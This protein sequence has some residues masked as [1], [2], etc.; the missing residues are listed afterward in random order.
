MVYQPTTPWT[1]QCPSPDWSAAADSCVSTTD[2]NELN[3]GFPLE[4]AKQTT[5]Y[6]LLD[7]NNQLATRT[8]QYSDLFNYYYYYA[9]LGCW[10][11]NHPQK[12]QILANLCVLQLY[13]ERSTVCQLYQYITNNG[14]LVSDYYKDEG[15]VQGVPWLYYK[16]KPS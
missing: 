14:S 16:Q 2:K 12:C 1:C 15:W 5:Y 6:S 4:Y 9:A 11:D 13:N 10:K 8:L 3:Q 7:A